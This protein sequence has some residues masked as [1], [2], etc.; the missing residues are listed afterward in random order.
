MSAK[1]YDL[2]E[3]FLNS[4]NYKDNITPDPDKPLMPFVI[5]EVVKTGC[6]IILKPL[7]LYVNGEYAQ[8]QL[9]KMRL[10]Q[11][12]NTFLL[13]NYM[14]RKAASFYNNVLETK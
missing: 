4:E 13:D 7:F 5:Y 1:I 2:S 8:K 9:D 12:H 14:E 6:S 10:E 11:P 3:Y